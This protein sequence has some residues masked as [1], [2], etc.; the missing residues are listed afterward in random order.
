VFKY[1]LAGPRYHLLYWVILDLTA[2]ERCLRSCASLVDIL[3]DR[4]DHVKL[5]AQKIISGPQAIPDEPNVESRYAM[6]YTR[7]GSTF[8]F[9]FLLCTTLLYSNHITSNALRISPDRGDILQRGWVFP[10]MDGQ[11]GHNVEE[12]RVYLPSR[13]PRAKTDLRGVGGVDEEK[14]LKRFQKKYQMLRRKVRL[15]KVKKVPRKVEVLP[16]V[17]SFRKVGSDKDGQAVS[18]RVLENSHSRR[19]GGRAGQKRGASR[20]VRLG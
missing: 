15:G 1:R 11:G 9:Y 17:G 3:L 12:R 5:R 18:K 19:K 2:S 7:L 14:A 4:V 10:R 8:A 13:S 20:S 6:R 16:L